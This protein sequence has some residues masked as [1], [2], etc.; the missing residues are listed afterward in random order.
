MCDVF[1]KSNYS[2]EQSTEYQPFVV[3]AEEQNHFFPPGIY[4]QTVETMYMFNE[5]LSN[6]N[7]KQTYFFFI[8][9]GKTCNPNI[10]TSQQLCIISYISTT[11]NPL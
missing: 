8:G 2:R 3:V 5:H 6:T 1:K 11:E 10:S 9:V 7:K 4:N